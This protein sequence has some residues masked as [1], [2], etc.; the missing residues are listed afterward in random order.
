MTFLHKLAKRLALIPTVALLISQLV[1]SCSQG[2]S[3]DYLGPDPS[4]PN[5]SGSY[6]GLSVTPHDPQLVQGDSIRLQA[7]GWL[8][9]G[10][11]SLASV[12]WSAAGGMVSGDGWYRATS[13]GAFRVRAVSTANAALSDSVTI[14]VIP[15]GGIAR[16]DITPSAAPLPAGTKQQFTAVALMGDGSRMYPTVS[17]SATGG[18]ISS[19]GLFTAGIPGAYTITASTIDGALLGRTQGIVGAPALLWLS[20]DPAAPMLESGTT[21]QFLP[22][23]S[24]SDGSTSVPQLTWTATGGAVTSSGVYTAGITPGSYR[25]IASSALG[26]ADTANVTILPRTL[27]IRLSPLTALLALE[28]TQVVTA[29][30]IRNDGTEVP[31]GV[32]WSAEG[33]TISLDGTYSA[34]LIPGTY[35][36]AGTLNTPDGRVLSDTAQF[37]VGADEATAAPIIVKPDTSVG[38]GA[39]VQFTASSGGGSTVPA[40]TWSATGGSIDGQGL[41]TAGTSTGSFRVIGKRKNSTKA[42]TA[43]VIIQPAPVVTVSGFTITPQSDIIASGQSRQFSATLS[44]S[45]GGVHP[46]NIAW[47]SAGGTIT[48]NGFYT[49][50]ALAGT[51]LVIAT[52]GCGAAD[53]ASV[54]I[55]ATTAPVATL[56]QLVLSPPTVQLVPGASQSFTVAGVWSDGAS[57]PPQV[58]FVATG[59]T[60]TPAGGYVAGS[61]AGTY[62]V[63]AT[64]TGGTLAD[65]SVVTIQAAGQRS[66]SWCSIH[67]PPQFPSEPPRHSW[68]RRPGAMDRRRCLR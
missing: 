67:R 58:T 68:S 49:A 40:V 31:V 25:V 13:P 8:S 41:Y 60:I 3:Q 30:A 26:K 63:I 55:P 37:Q 61:L 15:P 24:W 57:S 6:I 1:A 39:R 38:A 36:V 10:L 53:T 47:V 35:A 11:S 33:G 42:D 22:Y 48:Q 27:A 52:C 28:A 45:D 66:P 46:Y 51:Y 14:V 7:R 20:L 4:K 44:W 65:T 43:T 21:T 64:Q 29:Y 16:L 9:S 32:Q 23:A 54:T 2:S 59:G 12:S 5:P 19:T 50:G 56:S 18:T 62:R 34:G 17:W